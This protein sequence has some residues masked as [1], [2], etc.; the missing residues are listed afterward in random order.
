[1]NE[2]KQIEIKRDDLSLRLMKEPHVLI[3]GCTGSGKSTTLNN[4]IYALTLNTPDRIEYGIID[5]KRVSLMEWKDVP[6]CKRYATTPEEALEFLDDAIDLMEKRFEWM[7]K[8]GL[9][10]Y[11]GTWSYV[12]VDE[13]ADLLDT[14]KDSYEL[15]KRIGRLGRA[16]RVRLVLCTQSPNRKTIPADLTLNITG[17]LALRC[18]TAIESRQILNYKGAETLP[19]FGEGLYICP[20]LMEPERVTIPMRTDAEISDLVQSWKRQQVYMSE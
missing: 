2:G 20:E 5:L 1:M 18:Q 3:A 8:Q 10:E 4:F 13:C 19:R 14:V 7:E 16:A 6:H 9:K 11:T 15:L 12:I 17:R